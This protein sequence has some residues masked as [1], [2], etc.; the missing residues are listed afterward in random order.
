MAAIGK[1]SV[2]FTASTG[3][4]QS[5]VQAA[6]RAFQG[7]GGDASAL[8][9]AL[10]GLRDV[11]SRSLEAAGPA[12]TAAAAAFQQAQERAAE[13]SAQLRN[14]A[15]TSDQFRESMGGLVEQA[16][17]QAALFK[18]GAD[19]SKQYESAEAQHAATVAELNALRAA[20]AVT[21]DVYN[22]ASAAAAAALA[23]ANGSAQ[24][25]KDA[26]AALNAQ[27]QQ[28]AAIVASV[29][30]AEEKHAAT[31]TQLKTLL[32]AN[33]IS[34]ETYARAER[35]AAEALAEGN[36]SRAAA[37]AAEQALQDQ[38]SRAAAIVASV[39]TAEEKHAATLAELNTLLAA[40]AINAETYSRAEQAA[41]TALAEGNGARA[42]AKAAEEA[43]QAQRERAAAIV[44]S[45]QTAE[46]K[47]AATMAELNA[48]LAAGAISTE[49]YA[50]AEQAAATALAEANG[51]REAAKAAEQALQ[52][53]RQRAAAIVASVQT[54]EEKYASTMAELTTLLREGAISTE[55]FARAEQAAATAMA[56]GNGSRERAREA[57]QALN[58]QRE[59]AAAIVQSVQTAEER[60]S[61]TMVELN[62]LLAAGAISQE[63]FNRASAA[64]TTTMQNAN[65]S[66]EQARAAQQALNQQQ[67][68]AA[69][70]TRS[71]ATA[72][73]TYRARVAELN[74]LLRAGAISQETY[75]RA[76][77]Q[78]ADAM[79]NARSSSDGFQAALNGIRSRLTALIAID[80]AGFFARIVQS[81]SGYVS[82]LVAMGQQEANAIGRSADLASRLGMTYGEFAGLSYAASQAG[83]GMEQLGAASQK[84]ELSFAA[85]AQGPGQARDAFEALGLSIE[86][87]NG[88]NASDRFK[89]IG[90]AI[91]ALPTE[92]ERAQ[93]A[94]RMF[95]RSGA[96]LLPLFN[97]GA[98]A[99]AAA[100]EQ[101]DKFGL[102]L[103]NAQAK[104]VKGMTDGFNAAYEAVRGVVQQVVARLAPAVTAVTQ[105]FTTLISGIGGKNIGAAIGDA[106]LE[107]ARFFAGVADWFIANVPAVWKYVLDVAKQWGGVWDA[108]QRVADFFRGVANLLEAAFK[109]IASAMT[110]TMG[111]VL[112][113]V[114]KLVSAIPGWGDT[115]D[116]IKAA[117]TSL[118]QS[119]SQL[120]K[121]AGQAMN[122]A[123]QNFSDA[124]NG[125]AKKAGEEI[126]GPV[127]TALDAAIAQQRASAAA[128]DK[129]TK[130]VEITQKVTVEARQAVQGTDARTAEGVKEYLRILRG[131]TGNNVEQQQLDV[132]Q[133]MNGNIADMAAG[134][135]VVEVDIAA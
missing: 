62:T 133:E 92:A 124:W 114:G 12:A 55:T 47:Q 41:A 4:L 131:D 71:V 110:Q 8:R 120:F 5:G 46:E 7:L 105:A 73:E 97:Q 74:T 83:V 61:A 21:L 126:A 37:R 84:L 87:L 36:G 77:K 60:Y 66:T 91:A 123:G 121:E 39:Q 135:G 104:D 95:G 85:A 59:R 31:L 68:R 24:A 106:I 127:L 33:A 25:A 51:S 100:A 38:R 119:S 6:A 56:E 112:Q 102:A 15:I 96:E 107:G 17:Q 125:R 19:L 58:A 69:E 40:G 134:A 89:A 18:R 65:A 115:A 98:G 20:G 117:G 70:V 72:K 26:E 11:G 9:A 122:D 132:L 109:T 80:L 48:L 3:N 13:L 108:G 54:A 118:R 1:V 94:V 128:V 50:R 113:G 49:T 43:L 82:Q 14:G 78:A 99:I 42:A 16:T 2:A 101:A 22:A 67:Q 57:E 81:I 35:A 32:D 28:A 130:P 93:A 103:T 111:L 129:A 63:T 64:A 76:V 27:R 53:Q 79:K 75:S 52:T 23:Q 45:V 86:Q 90:D 29:Q 34:A 116:Q 10:A 88:M 44:L 30:T